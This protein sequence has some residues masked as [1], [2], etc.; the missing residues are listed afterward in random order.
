M[1]VYSTY[2]NVR[3]YHHLFIHSAVNGHVHCFPIWA[4]V[5]SLVL[6][7]LWLSALTAAGCAGSSGNGSEG[8][9][10]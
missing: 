3:T 6:V 7:M 5:N 2:A 9:R 1:A 8:R 4:A 10:V